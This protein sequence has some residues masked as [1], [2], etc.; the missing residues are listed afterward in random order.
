MGARP[1][2][3][4]RSK[5]IEARPWGVHGVGR[6]MTS[7]V[8]TARRQ[9]GAFS[10]DAAEAPATPATAAHAAP[11]KADAAAAA[12]SATVLCEAPAAMAAQSASR[13]AKGRDCAESSTTKR[14]RA[15]APIRCGAVAEGRDWFAVGVSARNNEVCHRGT[16]YHVA[17]P[18]AAPIN[19]QH[20][21]RPR[22]RPIRWAGI[23]PQRP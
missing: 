16:P 1:N 18:T 7:A 6:P 20:A 19:L 21:V 8:A 5:H 12:I 22:A 3:V 15:L 13:R 14:P 9:A 4:E 23:L 2:G 17:P 10:L 11:N